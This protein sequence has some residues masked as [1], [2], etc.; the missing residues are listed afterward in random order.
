MTDKWHVVRSFLKANDKEAV[1][2]LGRRLTDR[3]R[4][5][6]G[7]APRERR[8]LRGATTQIVES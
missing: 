1:E 3:A 8:P 7:L 4:K 6:L 5:S 2:E